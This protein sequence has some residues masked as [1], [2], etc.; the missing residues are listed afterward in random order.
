VYYH[1]TY[2]AT[3]TYANPVNGGLWQFL[4]FPEN[5]KTQKVLSSTFTNSLDL[6]SEESIDGFGSKTTRVRALHV[7]TEIT[8]TA[9]IILQKIKK[10]PFKNVIT[11]TISEDYEL[12]K[13][14]DFRIEHDR[15]LTETPRTK[16]PAAYKSLFTF[17]TQKSIFDNLLAMNEW[18]FNHFAFRTDVTDTETSITEILEKKEGV[19]QDFTHVFCGLARLNQIPTRYVS[20]Y[21]H[22]GSGLVGAMQMHAW[23][24]CYIPKTGWTGFDPTN[25]L[26]AAH[27]HIKVAHGNDYTDCAPLKG[28]VFS[29]G[30]GD[31]ETV[32]TVEVKT[33]AKVDTPT[34]SRPRRAKMTKVA[35]LQERHEQWRQQQQ[36]QQ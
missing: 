20:G 10:N 19:C 4:I 23:V 15:F 21:L 11:S 30:N 33:M 22:Q 8:F 36:Q 2:T 17:D 24:E 28:V 35:R 6:P 16:I 9:V 31:N 29:S 18:S 5:N 12:L 27:N 1:I 32:Y 7:V 3:N 13:S 26:M 25:N 14:L 34:P